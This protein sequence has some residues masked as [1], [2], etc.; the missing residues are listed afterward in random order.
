MWQTLHN[1]QPIPLT[2]K[3]D[4]TLNVGVT[5]TA[6]NWYNKIFTLHLELHTYCH[7]KVNRSITTIIYENSQVCMK[8]VFNDKYPCMQSL[9]QQF[10]SSQEC[11]ISVK[12]EFSSYITSSTPI[13]IP[14]NPFVAPN[15]AAELSEC[16]LRTMML[17]KYQSNK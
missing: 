2:T 11:E 10:I 3:V 8:V 7:N 5:D 14:V 6:E 9:L 17:L 13:I 1:M 12:L 4:P 15:R 16:F